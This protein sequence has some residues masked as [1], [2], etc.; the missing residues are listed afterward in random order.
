MP[1]RD[2]KNPNQTRIATYS[3]SF[4]RKAVFSANICAEST[5][6]DLR[7][8]LT[9]IPVNFG[10]LLTAS[11]CLSA[12]SLFA[13]TSRLKLLLMMNA[14]YFSPTFFTLLTNPLL[15]TLPPI[16]PP[17]NLLAF[18]LWLLISLP[19]R[20]L[21]TT[22]NHQPFRAPMASRPFS[23]KDARLSWNQLRFWRIALSR[24]E[25]FSMMEKLL[26]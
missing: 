11:E 18:P 8:P 9:M 14:L 3:Y 15:A 1:I 5:T 6:L 24:K 10:V 16:C 26:I 2:G 4:V 21:L 20:L 13:L 19:Y 17:S 25:F 7:L 23:L 22:L 12:R